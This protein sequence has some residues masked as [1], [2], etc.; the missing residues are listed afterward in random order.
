[1]SLVEANYWV[2]KKCDLTYYLLGWILHQ[3]L[4]E[5]IVLHFRAGLINRVCILSTL[6]HVMTIHYHQN[7]GLLEVTIIT[8]VTVTLEQVTILE[9][10]S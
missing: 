6:P 9:E 7:R 1:M 10:K 4:C 5:V 3:R 8:E 2:I